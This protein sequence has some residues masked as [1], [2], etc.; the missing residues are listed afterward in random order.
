MRGRES[1]IEVVLG[2][3]TFIYWRKQRMGCR[4]T[5]RVS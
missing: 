3:M 5:L 4:F 2:V 1:M